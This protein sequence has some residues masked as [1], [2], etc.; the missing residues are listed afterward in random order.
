MSIIPHT[1]FLKYRKQ[2]CRDVPT[3]TSCTDR[4]YKGECPG[5]DTGLCVSTKYVE[6]KHNIQ[7]PLFFKVQHN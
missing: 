1:V 7:L 5:Y 4:L 2:R 3:G 6:Q